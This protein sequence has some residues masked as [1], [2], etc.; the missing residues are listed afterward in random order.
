[1]IKSKLSFFVIFYIITLLIAGLLTLSGC[2]QNDVLIDGYEPP[3]P[4][5]PEEPTAPEEP[6][7]TELPD[8][9]RFKLSLY[10]HH[11]SYTNEDDDLA[12]F[13]YPAPFDFIGFRMLQRDGQFSPFGSQAYQCY[14]SIVWSSDQHP[15]TYRIFEQ[16]NNSMHLS[17]QWGSHFFKAGKYTVYLT[18][19]RKGEA[20]HSDSLSF[21]LKDRDFLGFDWSKCSATLNPGS[22]KGI[23]NYLLG[24]YKYSHSFPLKIDGSIILNIYLRYSK[25]VDYGKVDSR[26]QPQLEEFLE[27]HLGAPVAYEESDIRASFKQ[28]PSDVELCK[29]YENKTTRAIIVHSPFDEERLREDRFYIHVESK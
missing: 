3:T 20:V 21:E 11:P 4:D 15:D 19:Y 27:N 13:P 8:Y 23:Y 14:D 18:G 5:L 2:S 22:V 28:L 6:D 9:A 16:T 10:T 17:T 7:I 24:E 26:Q 12:A 1:M 29:L 25:S